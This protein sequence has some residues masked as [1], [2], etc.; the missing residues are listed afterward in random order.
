MHIILDKLQL[1]TELE[2]RIDS[3]VCKKRLPGVAKKESDIRYTDLPYSEVFEQ[4]MTSDQWIQSIRYSAV[5][6]SNL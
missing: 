4:I 6:I 3:S 2:I 1:G 5:K